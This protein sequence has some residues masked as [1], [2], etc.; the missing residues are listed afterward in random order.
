MINRDTQKSV[1]LD[2]EFC[3][4]GPGAVDLS[5]FM[6]LVG[7][8]MRRKY[9]KAFLERYHSKLIAS[10]KVDPELNTLEKLNQ[11]YVKYFVPR[12]M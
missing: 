8:E 12:N 9:E 11:D 10:S 5:Y 3:G 4:F 7:T 1:M 6:W 2:F